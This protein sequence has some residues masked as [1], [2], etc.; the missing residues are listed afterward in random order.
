MIDSLRRDEPTAFTLS[1]EDDYTGVL[2]T[3]IEKREDGSMNL[4]RIGLIDRILE[5]PNL[6]Y[7]RVTIR[8]TS[9]ITKPLERTK[10]VLQGKKTELR[11]SHWHDD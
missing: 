2:R 3:N 7:E 5:A 4:T 1:I 9:A 11:F 8:N 10:M 6:N